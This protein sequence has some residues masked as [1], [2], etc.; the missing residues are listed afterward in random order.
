MGDL[1]TE[2][3]WRLFTTLVRFDMKTAQSDAFQRLV[4]AADRIPRFPVF[5]LGETYAD[6]PTITC[7]SRMRLSRAMMCRLSSAES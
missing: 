1:L 6:R 2:A 7:T 3:D 4:C 5:N